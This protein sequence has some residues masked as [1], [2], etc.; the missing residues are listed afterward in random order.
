[1]IYKGGEVGILLL[2]QPENDVAARNSPIKLVGLKRGEI[3][4]VRGGPDENDIN[5]IAFAPRSDS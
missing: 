1:M 5:A 2:Q 4:A 3:G